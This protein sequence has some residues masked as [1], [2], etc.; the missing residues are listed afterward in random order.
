MTSFATGMQRLP[1]KL[2]EQLSP[3]E[4]L[5]LNAEVT[6]IIKE[7]NGWEITSS[8]G[9]FSATN[10]VIALPVNP[11]LQL[12]KQIEPTLPQKSIPQTQIAT[13]AFGFNQGEKL[14]PGFGYLIPECENR[15]TLGSLFSSNMF[16]GRAP[17]NHIVFE[18]LI[19]GRR[20]PEK[21]ELD[22]A[23]LT[24]KAFEDVREVL[25]L[26]NEPVYTTV[27]RSTGSIPQLEQGYPRLLKWRNE[28]M[29]SRRG[30]HICGFGW[31][32]IGLNDMMKNSTR[33]AESILSSSGASKSDPEVKSVYF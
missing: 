25:D 27:L 17:E 14:P 12:L 8:K 32:G 18:T 2:T 5:L 29:L 28:L 1:E 22:D 6:T 31:E 26:P 3:G 20:H 11:A 15:F 4:N 19:G 7:V 33:I 16:S 23:T 21:L 24:R 30:I 9:H 10:L 13:V